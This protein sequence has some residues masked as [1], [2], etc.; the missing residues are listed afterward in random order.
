MFAI[1]DIHPEKDGQPITLLARLQ[2]SRLPSAKLAFL[3]FR[4][5]V[6][7][8]QATLA[9]TPEKISRQMVKWA[10]A[11]TPESI[12]RV[13][14]TISKV[15]KPVES[16]SVTVKDAEIKISR[17]FVAVPVTWE[18]QIP[19]YVDDATRSDAEIEASQNTPRPLPPIAL[20]TRLDNRVLDL[21]TPT[22]QA[23]FRLNHGVCLSLIHI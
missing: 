18:G 14:G 20:D 8:V 16:P 6:H 7:C 12:V 17:M 22:N 9:V 15:P 23:I 5:G 2:T 13:E 4:N 1:E 10:A 3:T 11:V 21:R 19:F